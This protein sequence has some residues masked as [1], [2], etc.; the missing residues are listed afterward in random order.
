MKISLKN[1]KGAIGRYP[2]VWLAAGIALL[3]T[4]VL[5]STVELGADTPVTT[6]PTTAGDKVIWV[7]GSS[8]R[9]ADLDGTN[10][11]SIWQNAGSDV[12][13]DTI[14]GNIYWGDNSSLPGSLM[15]AA[16]DGTGSASVVTTTVSG[17]GV[18]DIAIDPAGTGTAYW[19]DFNALHVYGFV[20]PDG[21]LIPIPTSAQ[22]IRG[23]AVDSR[24]SKRYLY[25]WTGVTLLRSDLPNGANEV[26][27]GGIGSGHP[28]GIALDTCA[29]AVYVIAATNPH[30]GVPTPYIIRGDL[31]YGPP[32]SIKNITT[33]LSGVA[34]VG[35][36]AAGNSDIA[37]DLNAGKMYWTSYNNNSVY[38]VHSAALGGSG[39]TVL[40]VPPG[41]VYRGITLFLGDPGCPPPPTHTFGNISSRL[42]V[43][44]GDNVLIAG[45]IVTGTQPK[46]VIG[47]AIG[48]SLPFAGA[49]ADPVLELRNSS[50][51]LIRSND[52]W[53]DDPT[54]ESEIGATGI[55]PSNNLEA[56]IVETLPANGSA[57]TAIVRGA[58]NGTGI[59]VVEAYDLDQTVDS[60]LANISTRGLV[61][62]GD[63]VLIGGL[64]V[65]GQDPLRVIVRAIGPSLPVPGALGN[66]TIDLHDG[67]G[68]LIAFNDNWRDDPVQESEIIA[69][70]IPPA[71]DLES[72]IVQDLAPGAY[73]AIVRG[74]NNLTGIA[75]VEAYGLN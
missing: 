18:H 49:L 48:P 63:T 22:T 14:T 41:D 9:S 20:L 46:R 5:A 70:G 23:I 57:Y 6:L 53:R 65:L 60:K 1:W 2:L 69:T 37:L 13:I 30:P 38:E 21:P 11:A 55:P 58:N 51:G 7:D 66:P 62:T 64:I 25:V 12:A 28:G 72:A 59:G 32:P 73:T 19:L 50:G 10:S 15:T 39:N 33:V 26:T 45:F 47:R 35:N 54:Q 17:E 36:T 67:N 52:N 3:A 16:H 34:A 56:A 4:A 29:E 27:V 44:T 61:Q 75:L 40:P 31:D 42:T 71:N 8:I 74:A 24:A 43:Q 68:A